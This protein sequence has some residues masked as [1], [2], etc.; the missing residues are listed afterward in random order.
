VGLPMAGVNLPS[1]FMLRPAVEGVE[2]LV[3]AYHDGEV[4]CLEEAEQR[5]SSI[6]GLNVQVGRAGGRGDRG[7][8]SCCPRRAALQG[9]RAARALPAGGLRGRRLRAGQLQKGAGGVPAA[10]A[11]AGTHAPPPP[12][13][14]PQLD[15][16]WVANCKPLQPRTFLMRMLNNLKQVYMINGFLHRCGCWRNLPAPASCSRSRRQAHAIF[17]ACS[18]STRQRQ[19]P[20]TFPRH[21]PPPTA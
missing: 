16:K 21:Q 2:L 9:A 5:L 20:R 4:L 19:R 11:A 12:A 7:P 6:M 13:C 10:A 1:H 15:P 3:D 17:T 18:P 14:P 8:G